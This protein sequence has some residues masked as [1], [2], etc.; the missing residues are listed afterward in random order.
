MY[1]IRIGVVLLLIIKEWLYNMHI[2]KSRNTLSYCSTSNN[3]T[4]SVPK[5]RE[6]RLF[7]QRSHSNRGFFNIFFKD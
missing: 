6:K 2:L 7:W 5:Q 4:G 1:N 3:K